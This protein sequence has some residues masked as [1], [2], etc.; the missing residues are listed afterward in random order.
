MVGQIEVD[1]STEEGVGV[2]TDCS[3][4]VNELD[5]EEALEDSETVDD[6]DDCTIEEGEI[7]VLCKDDS[8]MGVAERRNWVFIVLDPKLEYFDGFSVVEL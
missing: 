6:E 5:A 2:I 1:V 8:I 3:T 7:T 4:S